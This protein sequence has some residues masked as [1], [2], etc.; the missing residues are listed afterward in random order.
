M[1]TFLCESN[2]TKYYCE[3]QKTV[4][5]RN[6]VGKSQLGARTLQAEMVTKFVV[7]EVSSHVMNFIVIDQYI[8]DLSE[9]NQSV[10]AFTAVWNMKQAFYPYFY[11]G[12]ECRYLFVI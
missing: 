2:I 7:S 4:N 11:I 6:V 5:T 3:I 10:H 9:S 8:I 12:N 1:L